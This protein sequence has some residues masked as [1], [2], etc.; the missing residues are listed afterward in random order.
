MKYV[1]IL[2]AKNGAE[3]AY[4]TDE[5]KAYA[6]EYGSFNE[7]AAQ[8][9]VLSGGNPVQPPE[10]AKTVRVKGGKRILS[11]APFAELKEQIIGYYVFECSDVDEV[12]L[13]AEKIPVV[14]RG[15]GAVEIRPAIDFS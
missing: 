3:P 12:I 1:F 15:F 4:G 14:A 5:W 8:A 7:E 11:D 6:S 2:V 10:T 9:G 13:W